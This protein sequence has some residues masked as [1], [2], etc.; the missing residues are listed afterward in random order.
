[1]AEEIRCPTCGGLLFSDD[2]DATALA[3]CTCAIA[4]NS[5]KRTVAKAKTVG[6]SSVLASLAATL[7]PEVKAPPKKPRVVPT[8]HVEVTLP[9]ETPAAPL[10]LC[11]ACGKNLAGHRRFRDNDG[12]YWCPGCRDKEK[13]QPAPEP[14]DPSRTDCPRCGTKI[15][16]QNLMTYDGGL[17]CP[18]C[19]RQ[20]K[21]EEKLTDNRLKKINEAF[22]EKDYKRLIP[23][24]AIIGVLGLIMLLRLFGL[25]GT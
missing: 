3:P 14:S 21:E 24:F 2:P 20:L 19:H 11:E 16:V 22:K 17:V 15:L 8:E 18:K 7:P 13:A 25:I 9:A 10:K 4:S 5:G 1:M 12:K 23:L 6:N